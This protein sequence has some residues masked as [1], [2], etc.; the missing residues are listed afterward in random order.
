MA[1]DAL[2]GGSDRRRKN[3]ISNKVKSE[4]LFKDIM[5]EFR[6]KLNILADDLQSSIAA[7]VKDHL[8]DVKKMLDII[9]NENSISE[10]EQNPEL[11]NRVEGALRTA[12]DEIRRIQDIIGT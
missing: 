4:T 2:G 7:A 11:R 10:S 6:D 12:R 8:D 1:N 3:I 9:R 5:K